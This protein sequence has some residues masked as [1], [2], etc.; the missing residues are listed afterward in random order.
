MDRQRRSS[1]NG[2]SRRLDR[3]DPGLLSISAIGRGDWVG[4]TLHSKINCSWELTGGV[5]D[6]RLDD[7]VKDRINAGRRNEGS[8]SSTV[9]LSSKVIGSN[10]LL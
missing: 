5:D 1:R 7:I 10:A 8:S 4:H 6:F 3:T 9:V 2:Q